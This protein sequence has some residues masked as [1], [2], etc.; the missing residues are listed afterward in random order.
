M[1]RRKGRSVLYPTLHRVDV[2]GRSDV[3]VTL[4]PRKERLF[5]VEEEVGQVAEL[6]WMLWRRDESL[7]YAGSGIKLW[8]LVYLVKTPS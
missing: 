5:C 4:P 3:A 2:S 8:I 7:A 6:L 1:R